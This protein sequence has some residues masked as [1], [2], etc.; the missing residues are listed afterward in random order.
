MIALR[1]T[2][3]IPYSLDAGKLLGSNVVEGNHNPVISLTAGDRSLRPRREVVEADD[4]EG[5]GVGRVDG[6]RVDIRTRDTAGGIAGADS[7]ANVGIDV[8]GGDAGRVGLSDPLGIR[9][10]D[11]VAS[12]RVARSNVRTGPEVR[13]NGTLLSNREI[14]ATDKDARKTLRRRVRGSLNDIAVR[15]G[16]YGVAVEDVRGIIDNANGDLLIG[17]SRASAAVLTETERRRDVARHDGASL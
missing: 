9:I 16:G 5:Q 8:G 15:V 10:I 3:M 13:P 17:R 7:K 4:A 6:G 2:A 11:N 14:L 1:L 12:D